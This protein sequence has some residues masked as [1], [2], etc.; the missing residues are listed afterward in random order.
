MNVSAERVRQQITL[1]LNAWGMGADP[2]YTTADALV[3]SDLA[4]IDT[5]GI[6]LLA[7]YEEY[8]TKGKA[9]FRAR[10]R[11][12]R[13]TPV[14][15]LVDGDAG[16]GHSAAVMGMELAIKKALSMGVGVV[17]VFNSHHFGAT[18]YY[19]ALAPKQGLIGLVTSTTR[20]V[21]VVPMVSA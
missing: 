1:V 12:V 3:Y 6:S 15:A 11:V 8:W 16:F 13:E 18:G 19:A 10:P 14:T 17:S 21:N 20:A 5:H 4:G 7:T 2:A 9:N